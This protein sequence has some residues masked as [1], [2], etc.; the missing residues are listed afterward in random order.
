MEEGNILYEAIDEGKIL[1]RTF[2]GPVTFEQSI[3]SW[4]D[5]I[6]M[7]VCRVLPQGVISD[8]STSGK[9]DTLSNIPKLLDFFDHHRNFFN[10]LISAAVV[11][12]PE[13]T[14]SGE[15]VKRGIADHKLPFEHELFYSLENAIRWVRSK[16]L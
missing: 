14:V 3:Q 7:K 5:V 6:E 9:W 16:I 8:F 13:K 4:I 10:G 15:L 2:T 1:I 12:Q 11:Q